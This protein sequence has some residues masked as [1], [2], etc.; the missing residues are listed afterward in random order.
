MTIGENDPRGRSP[1][2]RTCGNDPY[3]ARPEPLGE[4][5]A[6]PLNPCGAGVDPKPSISTGSFA[7][8]KPLAIRWQQ[9]MVTS[10]IDLRITVVER[11]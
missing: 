3:P 6:E 1:S 11:R 4:P 8:S 7:A 9:G 5:T 10:F 2:T